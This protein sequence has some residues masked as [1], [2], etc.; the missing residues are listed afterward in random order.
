MQVIIYFRLSIILEYF[1]N[2]FKK[3][4]GKPTINT[5]LNL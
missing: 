1:N 3:F 5:N 4:Q 2:T